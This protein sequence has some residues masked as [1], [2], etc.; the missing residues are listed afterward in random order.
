MIRQRKP[1]RKIGKVGRR[2][3]LWRT[4]VREQ[5]IKL[6]GLVCQWCEWEVTEKY[7]LEIHHKTKRSLGGKDTSKNAIAICSLC[8]KKA[9]YTK[10]AYELMRDSKISLLTAGVKD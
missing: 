2:K 5:Y 3:K 10:E 1:L 6:H 9:H 8:H 4:S 7:K